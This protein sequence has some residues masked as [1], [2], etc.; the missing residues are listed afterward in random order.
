MGLVILGSWGRPLRRGSDSKYMR[1]KLYLI[2]STFA[3]TAL[4]AQGSLIFDYSEETFGQSF[5]AARLAPS[6]LFATSTDALDGLPAWMERLAFTEG[7]WTISDTLEKANSILNGALE[8]LSKLQ[9]NPA[10]VMSKW[11]FLF[12]KGAEGDFD[13]A[14]FNR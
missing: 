3:L 12:D 7:G 8:G 1:V 6:Y 2:V 14:A 13:L 11:T 5:A 10:A 4:P 9:D